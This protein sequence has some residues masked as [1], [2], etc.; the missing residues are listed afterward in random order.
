M[1]RSRDLYR[2]INIFLVFILLFIHFFVFARTDNCEALNSGFAFGIGGDIIIEYSL[3]ISLI[4]IT[5][6]ILGI[7]FLERYIHRDI[8]IGVLILSIGNV[9]DRGL[10]GVCDYIHLPDIFLFPIPIFNLL[11]LGIVLGMC[12]VFVGIIR[13]IWKR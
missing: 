13:N 9:I 2:Y 4:S 11:D 12:L 8:L 6:L 1:K 10:G 5:F 7:F 3:V